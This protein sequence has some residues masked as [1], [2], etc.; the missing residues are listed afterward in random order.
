MIQGSAS[1]S[2]LVAMLAARTRTV[3]QVAASRGLTESEVISKLVAYGSDQ[4]HSC[5]KKACMV[6]TSLYLKQA[7]VRS[8]TRL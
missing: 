1:E 8:I 3:R 4:S 5:V 2:V 7:H 6:S